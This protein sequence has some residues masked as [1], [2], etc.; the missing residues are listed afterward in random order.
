MICENQIENQTTREEIQ[1]FSAF[2]GTTPITSNKVTTLP[3]NIGKNHTQQSFYVLKDLNAD[4]ILDSPF[5]TSEKVTIDYQLKCA[6]IGNDV[7]ETK[8]WKIDIAPNSRQNS[9]IK[10]TESQIK[11]EHRTEITSLL[12]EFP[13]LFADT[14]MPCRTTTACHKI[15]SL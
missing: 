10:L 7:R 14:L 12:N 2:S 11:T 5:L 4:A 15:V 1:T 9:E 3:I 13:E 8:Y 6:Y